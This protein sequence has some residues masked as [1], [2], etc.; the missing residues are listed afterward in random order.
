MLRST[1]REIDLFA[2]VC[3]V[4]LVLF[5]VGALWFAWEQNVAAPTLHMVGRPHGWASGFGDDATW[6]AVITFPLIAWLV[7][8]A[9]FS[10]YRR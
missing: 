8:K 5:T 4:L 10:K 9:F 1:K 7:R 2:L 3:L 6:I